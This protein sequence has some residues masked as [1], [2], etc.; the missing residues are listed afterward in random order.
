MCNM[1][2]MKKILT[3]C[4]TLSLILGCK[5]E[6][7]YKTLEVELVKNEVY[8]FNTRHGGDE[9]E[10]SIIR[11]AEHYLVSKIYYDDSTDLR[12]YEYQPQTDYVGTDVVQL[13]LGSGSNGASP[14]N[15][16][17][18]VTINFLVTD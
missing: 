17:E 4:L 9:E 5:D 1:R 2:K 6:E 7:I 12:L 11:Q 3:L 15:R 10:T 8:Y 14:S 18:Y 16:F 13:K